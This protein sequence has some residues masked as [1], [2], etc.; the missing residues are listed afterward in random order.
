MFYAMRSELKT[1]SFEVIEEIRKKTD[2]IFL[3]FDGKFSA[4]MILN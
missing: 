4:Q 3:Q 2:L 1:E